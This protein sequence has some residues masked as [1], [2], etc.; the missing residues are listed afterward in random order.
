MELFGVGQA[1][2]LTGDPILLQNELAYVVAI[3]GHIV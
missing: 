1:M 2:A 3:R